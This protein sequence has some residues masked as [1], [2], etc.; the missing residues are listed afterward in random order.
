MPASRSNSCL[1]PRKGCSPHEGDH[2]LGLAVVGFGLYRR[3]RTSQAQGNT[4]VPG[5]GR[6]RALPAFTRRRYIPQPGGKTPGSW[7]SVDTSAPLVF[8][9]RGCIAKPRVTPREPSARREPPTLTPTPKG[10]HPRRSAI[11]DRTPS[12]VRAYR[13]ASFP[14]GALGSRVLPGFAMEPLRVK[15]SG[16]RWFPAAVRCAPPDPAAVAMQRLR[17][18]I[19]HGGNHLVDPTGINPCRNPWP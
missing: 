3:R 7:V 13:P 4:W 14:Q 17:V 9:R 8:T 1:R 6:Y 2:V 19:N 16:T 12:G 10:L 5:S 18:K 11:V 15:H